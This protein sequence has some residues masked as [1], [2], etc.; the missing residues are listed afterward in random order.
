M[1]FTCRKKVGKRYGV[2]QC[3]PLV[4]AGLEGTVS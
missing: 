4:L 3:D 2:I 1:L